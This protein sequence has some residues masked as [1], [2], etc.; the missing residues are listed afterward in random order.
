MRTTY[1]VLA[2]L[3]ALL[4]VIQA[5]MIAYAIGGLFTWIDAGNTL[6][7]AV[8]ESWEDNPPD[9]EGSLGSFL[10]FFIIGGVLIPLLGLILLIVSFF[11]KVP[12]GV[13]LALVVFLAIVA[14]YLLG[15]FAA[16]TSTPL[17]SLLH[18]LNAF[19][20]FGAAVSAATAAKNTGAAQPSP[21]PTG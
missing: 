1:R 15:T 13:M 3:I 10:H 17:L 6:D 16:S 2:G 7:K 14:Q 11:A 5:A 12:R 18:G 8:I 20:V 21:A 4:V 19:I 9:F